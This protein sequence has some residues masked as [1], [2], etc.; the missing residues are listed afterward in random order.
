VLCALKIHNKRSG[1]FVKITT[2]LPRFVEELKQHVCD[3]R[4][5]LAV[6]IH[7]DADWRIR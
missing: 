2:V 1:G 3:F 7:D 4:T 5:G 6:L